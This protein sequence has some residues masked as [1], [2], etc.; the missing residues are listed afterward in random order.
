MGVQSRFPPAMFD[1]PGSWTFCVFYAVAIL[2]SVYWY[3]MVILICIS[4]ASNKICQG[5]L[6]HLNMTIK[7]SRLSMPGLFFKDTAVFLGIPRF[8]TSSKMK[9]RY[10]T[11]FFHSP[12]LW[13]FIFHQ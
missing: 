3:H 12:W 10:Y 6:F 11:H 8:H 7:Q 4:L 13:N 1:N 5:T 2:V 9:R